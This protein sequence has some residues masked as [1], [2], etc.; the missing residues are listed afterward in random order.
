MANPQFGLR[1]FTL[2]NSNSNLNQS[3]NLNL[4]QHDKMGAMRSGFGGGG[5]SKS[6]GKKMKMK[7]LS[8]LQFKLFKLGMTKSQKVGSGFNNAGRY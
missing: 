7:S 1:G 6:I 5:F 3:L 8:P 2:G 4:N